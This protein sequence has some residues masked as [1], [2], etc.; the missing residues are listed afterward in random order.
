MKHK[1]KISEEEE[2][3]IWW[4]LD[5]MQEI[6]YAFGFFQ[7]NSTLGVRETASAGR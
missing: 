1:I 3:G 2:S 7:Q 4:D 6:C 5:A